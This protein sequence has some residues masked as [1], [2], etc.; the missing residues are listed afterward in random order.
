MRVG[1]TITAIMLILSFA[2]AQPL[3]ANPSGEGNPGPA[4]SSRPPTYPQCTKGT[5]AAVSFCTEELEASDSLDVPTIS[6]KMH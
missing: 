4:Y 6:F 2:V 1:N 5:L 3:R